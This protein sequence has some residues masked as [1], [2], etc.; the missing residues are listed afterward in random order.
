MA[1]VVGFS[2]SDIVNPNAESLSNPPGPPSNDTHAA[3]GRQVTISNAVPVPSFGEIDAIA[4]MIAL[5]AAEPGRVDLVVKGTVSGVQRGWF[6]D[7]ALNAFRSDIDG[8]IITPV[9]LRAL[10][11]VGSELTYTV[12]P[13]GSGK[14][15]G[16]EQYTGLSERER[17]DGLNIRRPFPRLV[18]VRSQRGGNDR[19]QRDAD[20]QGISS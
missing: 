4:S 18:N 2:G 8:E 11:A 19:H 10:A 9:D 1:F 7:R 3:V 14:R 5:A 12:V 16:D 20:G 17:P 13:R 15:I 6:Y